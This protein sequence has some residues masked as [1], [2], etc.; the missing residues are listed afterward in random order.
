MNDTSTVTNSILIR[1]CDGLDEL[2]ACV[3]LQIEVWGYSGGDVI[4]RRSFVVTQKI[5]GQVFGAFDTSLP[6]SPVHGG[7]ENLVGFAMAM[8]AI[9]NS[10]GYLHSHMLAVRA[11]YRNRGIGRGLKL[12]QRDDALARNISLMEWTFDP[13]VTKNA[14][15]NIQRLGVIVRRYT[16][17]FYGVSSSY[18]QAGMPTDRLH[19][20]W[21]MKSSRVEAA[22]SGNLPTT[23]SVTTITVPASI[24]ELKRANDLSEALAVQAKVR[25]L[26]QQAFSNGLSVVGFT[27][28]IEGNG[29][30][31][32]G[33]LEE[34]VFS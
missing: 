22:L 19:A 8:P 24:D 25:E 14:F 1:S 27:R 33:I 26:F 32:L 30:F 31:Q 16:P 2:G 18:L 10:N 7:P 13:L 3:D 17:D 28:D 6:G 12:K 9:C 21:W 11:A 4:P 29:V 5:G 20:E 23:E 15:L 34:S